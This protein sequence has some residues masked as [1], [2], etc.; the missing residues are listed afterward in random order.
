MPCHA[1]GTENFLEDKFSVYKEPAPYPSFPNNRLESHSPRTEEVRG[2]F[3]GS[4]IPYA[5][6]ITGLELSEH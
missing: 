1:Y 4:I 5:D 6:G 3:D 2:D